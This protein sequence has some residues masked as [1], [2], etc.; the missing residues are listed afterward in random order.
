MPCKLRG[1]VFIC[2]FKKQ[3]VLLLHFTLAKQLI[4]SSSFILVNSFIEVF[5]VEK[6]V[7]KY[8]ARM[9]EGKT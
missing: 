4:P 2:F 1:G 6:I 8:S 7:Q 9:E 5:N 3:L